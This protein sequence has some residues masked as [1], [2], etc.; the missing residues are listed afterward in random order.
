MS[1]LEIIEKRVIGMVKL[2]YPHYTQIGNDENR[3]GR[4]IRQCNLTVHTILVD[5]ARCGMAAIGAAR[6]RMNEPESWFGFHLAKYGDTTNHSAITKCLKEVCG[7]ESYWTQTLSR[8]ELERSLDAGYPVPVGVKFKNSGHIILVVGYEKE[9]VYVHDPYG[10]RDGSN[11]YYP[12]QKIGGHYGEYDFYRWPTFAKI[13]FDNGGGQKDH[14]C[15][16]RIVT[17]VN[18]KATGI[19]EDEHVEPAKKS[20]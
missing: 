4:D 8:G 18:G 14:S 19:V 20:Q 10:S 16:G 11:D 13:A 6:N 2:D 12:P 9:G 15:W 7:I 5:G 1:A 3:H 17:A